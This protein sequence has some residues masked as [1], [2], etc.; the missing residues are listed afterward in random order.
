MKLSKSLLIWVV[1]II[2]FII[3]VFVC[4][5]VYQLVYTGI[6]RDSSLLSLSVSGSTTSTAYVGVNQP[7][8]IEWSVDKSLSGSQ[9]SLGGF[10]KYGNPI[11]DV[12]YN[13]NMYIGNLASGT[14]FYTLNC[15][16]N[17]TYYMKQLKVVSK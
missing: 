8:S 15:L 11:R 2:G 12:S 16:Y 7:L 13:G 3:L 10:D 1:G 17:G 14:Y 6:H 9:C 4:V 5:A